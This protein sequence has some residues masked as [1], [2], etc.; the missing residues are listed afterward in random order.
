M[1]FY[2]RIRSWLRGMVFRSR[3]ES[4]MDAELRFHV[5]S[6]TEDFVRSGLSHEASRRR[7]RMEFGGVE[8]TKEEC[9]DASSANLLDSFL[10]DLRFGGRTLGEISGFYRHCD[11]SR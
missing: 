11:T 4:E 3:T 1:S 10:Q 5:D 8:L 6:R 9:R 7:A 2:A